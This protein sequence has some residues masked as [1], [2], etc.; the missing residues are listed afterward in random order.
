MVQT[1]P[2]PEYQ[3]YPLSFFGFTVQKSEVVSSRL[4]HAAILRVRDK[5]ARQLSRV[6]ARKN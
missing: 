4:D 1:I 3:H 2:G 6:T 5:L